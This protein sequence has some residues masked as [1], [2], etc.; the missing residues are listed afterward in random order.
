[1]KT[2]KSILLIIA[3]LSIAIFTNAQKEQLIKENFLFGISN[4]NINFFKDSDN[5]IFN[6]GIEA[7][8]FVINKLAFI[9]GI[10]YGQ[11]NKNQIVNLKFGS[12]YYLF[13][14]VPIGINLKASFG[15]SH[16]GSYFPI[17]TEFNT[18]FSFFI[19]ERL[20]IEPQLNY[21]LS[22]VKEFNNYF[23]TNIYI[24]IFI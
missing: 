19:N 16:Y 6:I 15:R 22:L 3:F 1:M 23:Q 2:N 14:Y 20:T 7:G 4:E 17:Y 9:S 13:N 12:K 8:Q 21:N 24:F 5:T 10:G 18:G 11:I